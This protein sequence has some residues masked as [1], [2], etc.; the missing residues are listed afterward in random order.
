MGKMTQS[1]VWRRL[2]AAARRFPRR[3]REVV[4]GGR[5]WRRQRRRRHPRQ[6]GEVDRD[7]EDVALHGRRRQAAHSGRLAQGWI[8]MLSAISNIFTTK[9]ISNDSIFYLKGKDMK[10]YSSQDYFDLDDHYQRL[11]NQQKEFVI[12]EVLQYFFTKDF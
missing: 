9:R 3:R 5:H 12:W 6:E 11:C 7:E 8:I 2:L 4:V 1:T 10:E